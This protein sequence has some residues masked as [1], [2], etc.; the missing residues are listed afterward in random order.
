VKVTID[1]DPDLYRAVKGEAARADRSVREIVDEALSAWLE[2]LEEAEDAA[3]AMEALTEYERDGGVAEIFETHF[4][5]IIAPDIHV[6][7]AAPIVL[8]AL[9]H[10]GAAGRGQ[11]VGAQVRGRSALSAPHHPIPPIRPPR[12]RRPRSAATR[13][14]GERM[15]YDLGVWVLCNQALR[16]KDAEGDGIESPSDDADADADATD[17]VAAETSCDSDADDD[18]DEVARAEEDSEPWWK[19]S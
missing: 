16:A 6:E 1:R 19:H 4:V 7:V 15:D 14:R 18:F 13:W 8:H 10:D 3:A 2:R 5:E 11:G 9:V 12:P 17:D